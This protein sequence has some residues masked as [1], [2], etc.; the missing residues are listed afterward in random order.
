MKGISALFLL[1]LASSE[2]AEAQPV[3]E[4]QTGSHIP[5]PRRARIEERPG[6]SKIDE[7]RLSMAQFARCTVDR[8][9]ADVQKMLK[10]PA[11][12]VTATTMASL[13]D[14]ECL[15]SGQMSFSPVLLRGALFAELYRRRTAAEGRGLPWRMAVVPFDP[16]AVAAEG[17][18]AAK[19]QQGLLTFASCV[20]ARDSAAAKSVVSALPTSKSQNDAFVGL[21]P[22]LGQCLFQDQKIT[23]SKIVLEGALGEVLYRGVVT[24]TPEVSRETK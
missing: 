23:L 13:A 9:A 24:Q 1:C 19:A 15:E 4:Q 17:S 6:L 16:R 12:Q 10:L 18:D 8:R 7:G 11:D 3:I 22:N 20:V 2:Y 5:I 21:T 14:D